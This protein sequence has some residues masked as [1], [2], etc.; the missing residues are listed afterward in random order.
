MSFLSKTFKLKPE[1]LYHLQN[2]R[3][4]GFAQYAGPKSLL[5]RS[6]LQHVVVN[7]TMTKLLS[8]DVAGSTPF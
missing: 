7:D 6:P 5:L 1:E 2:G 8:I 4:S 3:I